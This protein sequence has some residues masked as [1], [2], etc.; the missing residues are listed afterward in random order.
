LRYY[1]PM[2]LFGRA[3]A[4]LL[5]AVLA[6]VLCAVPASAAPGEGRTDPPAMRPRTEQRT[7]D[8]LSVVKVRSTASSGARS[9]Q[10]L[11]PKREGTGVVLDASGLVLTIGYLV[12]E[13]ETIELSTA[14]GTTFPANVVGY[15]SAT[16]FGLLRPLRPLPITPVRMGQSSGVTPRDR[17]LIVGF[18]GVAPA[19]VVS[20]RQFVGYWEYL[21]DEAIYT[22]PATV[23]WSGAALLDSEGR[24]LGIGSLSVNDAMGS[25]SQVPGNMFVPIDLL[26]PLLADLV[27]R[28]RSSARPRPWIGVQTQEVHGNVIVTRVYEDSPAQRAAM[29]PGDVIISV[30]GQAVRAQAEFYTRVWSRGAAGVEVPLEVLRAGKIEKVTVTSGDRDT[31]YRAKPTY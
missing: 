16:G 31:Y 24:L 2:R 4:A 29:R 18:D 6:T 15:D 26:K 9:A 7:V 14:D 25:D 22:A 5:C 21:L 20:R 11:G 23:N 30:G 8:A 1:R 10:T 17:V 3:F 12:L 27:A 28:G 13:A 19:V